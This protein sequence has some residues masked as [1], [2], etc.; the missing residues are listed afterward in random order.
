MNRRQILAGICGTAA[1]GSLVTGTSALSSSQ[2][3]REIEVAIQ[4]D[5]DSPYLALEN[6]GAG[7]RSANVGGNLHFR[8]PGAYESTSATGLGQESVYEFVHDTDGRGNR[9]SNPLFVIENHGE[10]PI[11]VWGNQP[12]ETSDDG[13]TLPDVHIL[14]TDSGT[15]VLSEIQPAEISPG[16]KLGAGLQIDTRGV[17]T[18]ANGEFFSVP[19]VIHANEVSDG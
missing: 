1:A 6:R 9:A 10:S 11:E 8:F 18:T 15:R 19:L 12:F 3:Q 7:G 13:I 2:A 16:S 14:A 4:Q 5:G 17:D